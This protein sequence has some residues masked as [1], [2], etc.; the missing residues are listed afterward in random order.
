MDEG[1]EED[2]QCGQGEW[3]GVEDRDQAVPT[4]GVSPLRLPPPLI[5]ITTSRGWTP[6]RE[7]CFWLLY[8]QTTKVLVSPIIRL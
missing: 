2:R 4:C 8:P 3:S 7:L 1:M 6:F 5:I